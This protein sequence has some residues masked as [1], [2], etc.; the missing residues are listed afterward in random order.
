VV[1]EKLAIDHLTSPSGPLVA[2]LG[3]C[4]MAVLL[5]PG[6]LRSRQHEEAKESRWQGLAL[7]PWAPSLAMHIAGLLVAV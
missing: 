4:L 3:T 1:L 5:T 2:L 6:A 7:H